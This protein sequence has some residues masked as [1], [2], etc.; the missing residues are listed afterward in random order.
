MSSSGLEHAT[1]LRTT[2]DTTY[3]KRRGYCYKKNIIFVIIM[4]VEFRYLIYLPRN[5]WTI[6]CNAL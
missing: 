2:L 1:R 4:V 6:R 5:E 3:H